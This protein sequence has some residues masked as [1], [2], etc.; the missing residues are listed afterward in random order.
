MNVIKKL[1]IRSLKKNR[2]RTAVTIIGIILATA[3]LTAVANMAESM[4][5]SVILHQKQNNG[6]FHYLFQGVGKDNLKYFKNNKNIERLGYSIILGYAP[7]EGCINED[8]PYLYVCTYDENGREMAG[9]Q[10]IDGRMP[11]NENELVISKHIRYNGGVKLQIGDT[12]RL[13]IGR[14]ETKDGYTLEQQN[15]YSAGEETF[16][17]EEERE[18]TIV[19]MMERPNYTIEQWTAPGYT[20]ITGMGDM[21]AYDKLDVYSAYTQRGLKKHIQVTAGLLGISKEECETYFNA[22]AEALS[23]QTRGE[24]AAIADFVQR[25]TSLIRWELFRFSESTMSMIYSMAAVA[26]VIIIVSAVFCIRNSFV[27]SLTEKMR[28]YGM[29]ASVGATK[30]QKKKMVY[31]EAFILGVIG[32]PLGILSGVAATALVVQFTGKLLENS[33]G[34]ELVFVVSVPAMILGALLSGVTVF[35]SALRTAK[36][37]GRLSP[38]TAIRSNATIKRRKKELR[39]PGVISRI[40]GVGGV[41]AYKNLKRAKVKYRT[42]V[43]SIVVSV[44]V[45]IG[46]TAFI[47]LGFKATS[48]Y[49]DKLDYQIHFTLRGENAFEQAKQIVQMEEVLEYNLVRT[50]GIVVEYDSIP[51]TEDFDRHYGLKEDED[52]IPLFAIGADAYREYCK[53]QGLSYEEAKDKAIVYADYSLRVEGE[54]GA[55]YYTGKVAE[56]KQGDILKGKLWTGEEEIQ[57]FL[58]VAA[59]TDKMPMFASGRG[60]GNYIKAIVSDSWLEEYYGENAD[61]YVEVYL[62]CDDADNMEEKLRADDDF[63]LALQSFSNYEKEYQRERS[64]YLLISVFLYGFITV[65]ALIGVTNIFNTITTNMELRN[66]EFAMLR[67]IGMTGKEFRRMIWLE[68]LFYGVKALCIGI[69]IGCILAYCFH[70]A[71]GEGIVMDFSLPLKGITISIIAVLLLVYGIMRYSMGKIK[72]TNVISAMQNENI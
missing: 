47:N 48:V 55:K 34:V 66:R 16:I 39:T 2:K 56:F 22:G 24:M 37:A 60:I 21:G 1:T 59:Q 40:F 20:V 46:M 42:T 9:L 49:Y 8:K 62:V 12:L 30:R 70:R 13:K 29:I 11:E 10:L 7:L 58:E 31:Y 43:V 67:A 41:I 69:P 25:N 32:I 71:F 26:I 15:P 57:T 28:L 17:P 27:I 33:L 52:T 5:E 6:D 64:L 4:R 72:R 44:A 18:Y 14:R 35:L 45:F 53:S 38:I 65:I 68:S 19:G 23:E 50:A 61:S 63:E 3:L 54:D 51:Y 36:R